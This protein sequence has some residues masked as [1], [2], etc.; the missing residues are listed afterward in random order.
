MVC[1]GVL[2]CCGIRVFVVLCCGGVL[3]W[4]GVVVVCCGGVIYIY[5]IYII[6]GI[7]YMVSMCHHNFNHVLCALI[8]QGESFLN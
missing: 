7:W 4:C 8:K 6:Y 5:I 2:W 1:C 3:W